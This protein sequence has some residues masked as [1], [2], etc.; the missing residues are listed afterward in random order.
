M[1]PKTTI[2]MVLAISC[3]L[4]AA[5]MTNK[6]IADRN[7]N[8]EVAKV[9]VLV[10]KKDLPNMAFVKNVEIGRAHV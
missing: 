8:Q 5:F 1:K 3:G 9:K 2:L 7:K 6:L 4:A 10:A